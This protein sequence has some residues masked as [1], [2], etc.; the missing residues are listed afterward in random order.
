MVNNISANFL[1]VLLLNVSK[2]VII[3]W[4]IFT[5]IFIINCTTNDA[6]KLKGRKQGRKKGREEEGGRGMDLTRFL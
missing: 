1:G 5:I 3:I 4:Q 2:K 6:Q